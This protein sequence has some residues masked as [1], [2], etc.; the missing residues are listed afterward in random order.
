MPLD[1]RAPHDRLDLM[2]GPRPSTR[3]LPDPYPYETIAPVC[4][5]FVK[6][7]GVRTWY[8]QFGTTGPWL[9]FPPAYQIANTHLL[10]GVVP[11]L[12]QHYRIAVMDLRGNG[13]S[14]RPASP[15]QYSFWS[16]IVGRRNVR[17]I[18][19]NQN[20]RSMQRLGN[21]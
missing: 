19:T 2:A 3:T 1:T 5:G 6:R 20:Q 17:Y 16:K 12:A 13:R 4:E 8:A 15:D 18:C 11:W 14:D 7:D 9:A 21:N 10:K